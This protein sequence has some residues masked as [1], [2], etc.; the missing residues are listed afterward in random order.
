MDHLNVEEYEKGTY[1]MHN[2]FL[3]CSSMA[4]HVKLPLSDRFRF[5]P[6]LV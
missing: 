2:W 4:K 3:R 1:F 5:L 6:D